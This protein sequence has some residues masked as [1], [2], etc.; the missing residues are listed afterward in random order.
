MKHWTKGEI[1]KEVAMSIGRYMGAGLLLMGLLS[2]CSGGSG[3]SG[4]GNNTLSRRRQQHRRSDQSGM[5]QPESVPVM[6]NGLFLCATCR[7]RPA[8]LPRRWWP[9]WM[10]M[11]PGAHGQLI[12]HFTCMTQKAN[13][14]TAPRA[15]AVAS[16][17]R[18]WVTDLDGD[19]IYEIIVGQGGPGLCL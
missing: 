3:N 13:S 10:A 8:G 12:T 2:G 16:M 19:G 14:S 11:A 5:H 17:R 6:F 1:L 18:M 15:T 7:A 9:T 4:N